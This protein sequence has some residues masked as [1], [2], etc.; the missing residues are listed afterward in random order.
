M[1]QIPIIISL[2][3]ISNIKSQITILSPKS[4]V[5]KSKKMSKK[6]KKTK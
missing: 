6:P 5:E 3:L 2:T 1:F 4:F